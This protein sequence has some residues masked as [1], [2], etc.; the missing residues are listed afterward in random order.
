MMV[1]EQLPLS[2]RS[3]DDLMLIARGGKDTAFD[4]LVRR[5][6][7]RV[8]AVAGRLLG[9]RAALA[10]DAAQN[11]FLAIYRARSSYQP[12]GKFAAY[13][14]RVLLNQCRMTHR[15]AHV[16]ESALQG[17]DRAL[18]E[19]GAPA[20]AAVL[21]RERRREV[22]LALGRLSPKL[23]EVVV[24]RYSGE[25]AYDE[26]AESLGVPLGTVKRRLFDAMDRLRQSLEDA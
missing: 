13:L 16:E 8:L 26:I 10:P 18:P 21:A 5:Y 25:L 2:A 22:E 17:V 14:Y 11:T 3:D 12:R 15:N 9:Q 23:R 7:K 4:T 1:D 6:Q 19:V 20:D 24:L